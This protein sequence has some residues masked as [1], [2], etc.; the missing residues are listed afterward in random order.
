MDYGRRQNALA[1]IVITLSVVAGCTHSS[2][3]AQ[4]STAP[5]SAS[6]ARA[7]G[8][9]DIAGSPDRRYIT[10]LGALG[11]F[12]APAGSFNPAGTI[13]RGSFVKWLVLANNA[14]FAKMAEKQ[15]HP[16]RSTASAY[17]DVAISDQNF[18]YIQGMY[19]AGFD[20]GFPDKTF[21]PDS[22]L[23]REQ[24]IAIKESV[25]RGGVGKYYIVKWSSTMPNWTDRDR[26]DPIFRGA[27]AE[28]SVLD[29]SAVSN[30]DQPGMVIGNVPRA[31]GRIGEFRPQDP[32]TRAQAAALLWKIGPHNDDI[33][34]PEPENMPRSAAEALT[35]NKRRSLR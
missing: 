12:G 21:K 27:I 15:I 24:M 6:S 18:P 8:F 32:V 20:A 34:I 10:D 31:F 9:D 2:G 17:S 13:T 1:A 28:D 11:V 30:W 22:P 7:R 25:D 23:T 19:D 14:I 3:A 33:T 26:I 16:S 29:K 5:P 35:S 4:S